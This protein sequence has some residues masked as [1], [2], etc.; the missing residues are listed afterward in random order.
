MCSFR[1]SFDG[2]DGSSF[3][4]SSVGSILLG[5]TVEYFPS[6]QKVVFSSGY[7]V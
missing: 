2:I 4:F 7:S 6:R 1:R 5:A 3:Y